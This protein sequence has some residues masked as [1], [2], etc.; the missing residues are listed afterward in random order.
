MAKTQKELAKDL[1]ALAEELMADEG[2]EKTDK[3][4]DD[5]VEKSAGSDLRETITE[6]VKE[7]TTSDEVS[8]A[9]GGTFVQREHLD[10]EIADI[11]NRNTP[12]LDAIAKKQAMG[13][14]HEWDMVTSLGSNDT[15]VAEC[16][17]PN[18]NEA[19]I[20]RYSA[21]IKT[22]ATKVKVC[23]LAQ[24]AAK[25]YVDLKNFHLQRGMR[26]IL[27]D[28]EK[29]M[30]YGNHDGT[31]TTDITGAYR[32]ID[33]NAASDHVVDASSASV[34]QTMID[35]AIQ[36]IVDDGGMPNAMFMGAKDLRDFAA[37]W[38]NK[39]VYNDPGDGMTFGYNV[40]R[41]MSYAGPISIYLDPFLT[42]SNSP[43][44]GS[45]IFIFTLEETA[46]AQSEPMY[47]LPTYRTTALAETDLVVWN[48]AYEMR[49]P[50]WQAVI[51]DL[52]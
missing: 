8:T 6:V 32:L 49:I 21:Q 28:V 43:N 29:K 14:T 25:D 23:D 44:D 16:G 24:W 33:Q 7:I 13:K 31:S 47:R 22:Y 20:Q 27:Q 26:K 41:Y 34:S 3:T 15:A 42:S 48:I 51:K 18:D 11:T 5:G 39:V 1:Q 38:S 30:Y 40:A 4:E 37:L 12:L 2:A 52:G 36:A 9:S 10:K 50:Q 19:T 17:T 35:N 45:D 46:L